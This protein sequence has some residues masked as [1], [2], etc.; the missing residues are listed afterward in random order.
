VVL[1]VSALDKSLYHH[2]GAEF[3]RSINCG[4]VKYN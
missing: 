2:R 1:F 3:I 4:G